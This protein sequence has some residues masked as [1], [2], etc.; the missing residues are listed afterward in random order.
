MVH[1]TNQVVCTTPK[2]PSENTA[3]KMVEQVSMRKNDTS[4]MC[5]DYLTKEYLCSVVFS[6][7]AVWLSLLGLVDFLPVVLPLEGQVCYPGGE[8]WWVRAPV[9]VVP[10][11]Q[12]LLL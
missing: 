4:A 2:R 3:S 11:G 5:V 6:R 10:V 1:Q 7:K 12:V 9:S 8:G